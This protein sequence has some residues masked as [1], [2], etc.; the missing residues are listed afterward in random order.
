MAKKKKER[1]FVEITLI[2]YKI[3][4]FD[5][6]DFAIVI[7]RDQYTNTDEFRTFFGDD[8]RNR[9]MNLL[10]PEIDCC[11]DFVE[12]ELKKF[13]EFKFFPSLWDQPSINQMWYLD[14]LLKAVFP[15][16]VASYGR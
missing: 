14:N 7:Q 13:E 5:F 12:I 15:Y 11:K 2:P 10:V 6:G 1:C 9:F 4:F 8:Y 16:H 3:M